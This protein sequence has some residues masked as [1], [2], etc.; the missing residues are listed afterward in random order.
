MNK[1]KLRDEFEEII[2]NYR[3][4]QRSQVILQQA[5]IALFDGPS[6]SG[7]NTIISE[8]VKIG[9]YHQVVSDTTRLPRINDGLHEQDGR[10]YWFK[11][12]EAFLEGLKQGAY[13]EAAI[14]HDQ[15]VSGVS[16][17][18]VERAQVNDK[19]TAL[20]PSIGITQVSHVSLSYPRASMSGNLAYEPVVA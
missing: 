10:E 12:E 17:A 2:K 11:A 9:R 6:A 19:T 15:Q 14:I 13:V 8:L 1:L 20:R 7:R 18:E 5:R 16:V 3:A 4:S